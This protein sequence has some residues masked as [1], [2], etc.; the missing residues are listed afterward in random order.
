MQGHSLV[1][2]FYPT[3]LWGLRTPCLPLTTS[4]FLFKWM[5]RTFYWLDYFNFNNRVWPSEL[6]FMKANE[7]FS[8]LKNLSWNISPG[9]LYIINIQ[10]AGASTCICTLWRTGKELINTVEWIARWALL[11]FKSDQELSHFCSYFSQV[12]IVPFKSPN[13][14]CQW[15]YTCGLS[16]TCIQ[17]EV[18]NDT[19]RENHSLP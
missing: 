7:E 15:L 5:L 17:Q 14:L 12:H 1:F 18:E 3:L 10:E 11:M 6:T 8:C 9:L 13:I 2:V 19:S 16:A 4:I